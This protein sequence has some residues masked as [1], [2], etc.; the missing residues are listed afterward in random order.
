MSVFHFLSL[1]LVSPRRLS[2]YGATKPRVT[3]IKLRRPGCRS[4]IARPP[5]PP[6]SLLFSPAF[7]SSLLLY[8][9]SIYH[10]QVHA[11][12]F[13]AERSLSMFFSF[14]FYTFI[15]NSVSTFLGISGTRFHYFFTLWWRYIFLISRCFTFFLMKNTRN[16]Q[17]KDGREVMKHLKYVN[18]GF[19]HCLIGFY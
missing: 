14:S 15:H 12:C 6:P 2:G 7:I 8:I 17:Y 3:I 11:S 1:F 5:P 19:L 16:V 9:D 13:V 4:F 18:V 10:I